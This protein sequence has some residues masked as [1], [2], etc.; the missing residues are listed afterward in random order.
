MLSPDFYTLNAHTEF[1]FPHDSC[2]HASD[3]EL[4]SLLFGQRHLPELLTKFYMVRFG[5]EMSAVAEVLSVLRNDADFV[6]A[7]TCYLRLK[8]VLEVLHVPTLMKRLRDVPLRIAAMRGDWFKA[9]VADERVWRID[10]LA[11]WLFNYM[12]LVVEARCSGREPDA[13]EMPMRLGL[14]AM[15]TAIQE[16]RAQPCDGR[17]V[18]Q[19]TPPCDLVV[20]PFLCLVKGLWN[21]VAPIVTTDFASLGGGCST[22]T[23]KLGFGDHVAK[24]PGWSLNSPNKRTADPLT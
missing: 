15:N 12:I 16:V 1:P 23:A 19:H 9:G 18:W 13:I 20:Y 4:L 11:T 5:L 24:S 14:K 22:V 3:E 2:D 17:Y 21:A 7:A 6:L 10:C 8:F